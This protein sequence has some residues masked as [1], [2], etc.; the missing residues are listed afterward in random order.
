MLHMTENLLNA[1]VKQP[2]GE[3]PESAQKVRQLQK[4]ALDNGKEILTTEITT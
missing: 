3:S 1:S 2:L 4:V